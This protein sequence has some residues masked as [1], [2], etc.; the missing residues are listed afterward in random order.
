MLQRYQHRNIRGQIIEALQATPR[1][2]LSFSEL[3]AQLAD[4]AHYNNISAITSQLVKAG[5][6]VRPCHGY[7]RLAAPTP[8]PS[9]LAAVKAQTTPPT[10]A[11]APA[12][13]PPPALNWPTANRLGFEQDREDNWQA[14]LRGYRRA[15]TS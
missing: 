3:A 9:L 7:V 15:T 10:P 4:S 12:A 6:L 5:I 11:T 2:Q 13:P 1:G 8:A 14:I